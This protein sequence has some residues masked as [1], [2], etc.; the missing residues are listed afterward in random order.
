MNSTTTQRRLYAPAC[1]G[2]GNLF[3]GALRALDT[4]MKTWGYAP[5]SGQT[6]GYNCRRITGGTGYSLH[7]YGPG[8]LFT[9][10]SGVRITEAIAVD[11]NSL[12][13]PYGPRLVTDMPRQMVEAILAIR[14][15]SGRQL[16][17]WG[18]NY[19]TN[20]DAMHFEIV[21]DPAD[22][23]SGVNWKTVRGTAPAPAKLGDRVLKLTNPTMKGS[24]VA[25]WQRFLKI[26]DDGDFGSDTDKATR[27]FQTSKGLD[28]DG[29]VGPATLKAAGIGSSST[30][31]DDVL[32]PI[33]LK[34]G[35]DVGFHVEPSPGHLG[36]KEPLLVLN[37]H[38][39]RSV[40]VW[41]WQQTGGPG[42]VTITAGKPYVLKPAQGAWLHIENRGK[43]AD[44]SGGHDSVF[45]Q[46]MYRRV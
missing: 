20:K 39:G 30:E 40:P 17:G 22:L 26:A 13:N 12:A 14:T 4:V 8:G 37:T 41:I 33:H 21:C 38:G 36:L 43:D 25:E 7:A 16:F 32:L 31:E 35:E 24:D 42:L 46:L 10:W 11:I 27:N 19:R 1:Q 29:E 44:P 3:T 9:F 2:K 5:K 15:N 18:G 23:R 34:P 45:G 28:A 6:W